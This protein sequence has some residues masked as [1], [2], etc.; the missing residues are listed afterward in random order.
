M[1]ATCSSVAIVKHNFHLF[2]SE[3]PTKDTIYTSTIQGVLEYEIVLGL[4]AYTTTLIMRSRGGALQ[5]MEID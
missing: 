3:T 5:S 1:T 4:V 2:M